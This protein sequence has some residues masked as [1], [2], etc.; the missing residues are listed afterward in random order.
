MESADGSITLV[1]IRSEAN[2]MTFRLGVAI[3]V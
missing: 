3:G 1:P 2:L